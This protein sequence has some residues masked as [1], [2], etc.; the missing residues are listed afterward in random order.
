MVGEAH[1]VHIHQRHYSAVER[2][3][4]WS[5]LTTW[6]SLGNMMLRGRTQAPKGTYCRI[7]FTWNVQY[8]KICRSRKQTSGLQ[9]LVGEGSVDGRVPSNECAVSSGGGE[10]VLKVPSD[11]YTTVDLLKTPQLVPFT[12]WISCHVNFVWIF[13]KSQLTSHE[14]VSRFHK[15]KT[16]EDLKP[17]SP[18]VHEGR[19]VCR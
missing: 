4:P 2:V 11:F 1:S 16:M 9:G 10:N 13:K 15:R 12:R 17:R 3:K 14:H 7:L 19:W 18:S 5:L 6:M 8:R